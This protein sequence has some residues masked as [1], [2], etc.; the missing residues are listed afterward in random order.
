VDIIKKKIQNTQHTVPRTKKVN[1]LKGTSEDASVPLG[2]EKE[3]ITSGEGGRVLGG[4]GDGLWERV[5]QSGI[6]W[7]KRSEALR[8]S[9]KKGNRQP[10]EV[11]GWQEPSR[12]YKKPG[13]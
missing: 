7:G 10:W 13:R 1:K 11:G 3:A 9:R 8:A 5:I 6:G 12:L 4:K 2:R